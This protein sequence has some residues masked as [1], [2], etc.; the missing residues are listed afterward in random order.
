MQFEDPAEDEGELGD[1]KKKYGN[2]LSMIKD[3]FPQWSDADLLLAL[4][5]TD[6]DVETTV[7]RVAAGM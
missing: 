4:A 6:G 5:E 2:Q 1:M 7:E 3:I